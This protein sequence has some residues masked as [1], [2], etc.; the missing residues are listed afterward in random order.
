VQ[1]ND[2]SLGERET[3]LDMWLEQGRAA[4]RLRNAAPELLDALIKAERILAQHGYKTDYAKAAI[5]KAT[6]P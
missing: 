5:A 6:K 2:T 3:E 4:L 1:D